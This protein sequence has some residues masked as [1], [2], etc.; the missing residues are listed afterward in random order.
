MVCPLGYCGLALSARQTHRD[1]C[2]SK[3][4]SRENITHDRVSRLI[5]GLVTHSNR[6]AMENVTLSR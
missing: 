1:D 6:S 5:S 2:Y 4:L 3:E